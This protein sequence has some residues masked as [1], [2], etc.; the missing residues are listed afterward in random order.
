MVG[1][2]AIKFL[3]YFE[4]ILVLIPHPMF[5]FKTITIPDT[6]P[7][8][9]ERAI[10]SYTV[11]R[12]SYLDFLLTTGE[13]HENKY[14]SGID[15]EHMFLLTR[16]KNVRKPFRGGGMPMKI[17][18]RFRKDNN[19][20]SY[21][22]RLG[23]ITSII[24]C[25]LFIVTLLSIFHVFRGGDSFGFMFLLFVIDPLVGTFVYVEI[26]LIQ[27]LIDKAIERTRN[28][29]LFAGNIS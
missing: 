22:I 29:D 19:F 24:S 12:N 10:R 17:F 27:R 3:Y 28:D 13:D 21:Q 4:V 26:D 11:K 6:P 18:I 14:F 23:L 20:M 8:L 9:I 5:Y 7:E 1:L 2:S 16:M 15:R 25:F